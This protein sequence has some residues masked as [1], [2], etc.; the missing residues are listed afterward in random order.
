MKA[1]DR[2]GGQNENLTFEEELAHLVELLLVRRF[3]LDFPD[4]QASRPGSEP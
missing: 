2:I 4:I 3:G 1:V